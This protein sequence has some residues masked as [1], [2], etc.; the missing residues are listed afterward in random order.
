MIMNK[1]EPKTN[2]N[3]TE[4]GNVLHPQ[5]NTSTQ[6]GYNIPAGGIPGVPIVPTGNT[7]TYDNRYASPAY[8]QAPV[9]ARRRDDEP[10]GPNTGI[11]FLIMLIMFAA[12][13]ATD[14]AWQIFYEDQVGGV[15]VTDWAVVSPSHKAASTGAS[16]AA[17][18][19]GAKRD[20][21][22]QASL[23]GSA[24]DALKAWEQSLSSFVPVEMSSDER[25]LYER[26]WQA[27]AEG[28][29]LYPALFPC[30]SGGECEVGFQTQK[31]LAVATAWMMLNDAQAET[32]AELPGARLHERLQAV[33]G[34]ENVDLTAY[35]ELV[36]DAGTDTFLTLGPVQAALS[37]RNWGTSEMLES[38]DGGRRVWRRQATP[39]ADCM[40]ASSN[41]ACVNTREYLELIKSPRGSWQVVS[42]KVIIQ[43]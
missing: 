17:D 16:V 22:C 28:S 30:A 18:N 43:E 11:I 4:S 27:Q 40:A 32:W 26:L 20:E 9:I 8:P 14:R 37:A 19:D 15:N 34:L 23:A 41:C 35:E 33:F 6:P 38:S 21:N 2:S 10:K 12:G 5:S 7:N 3:V 25:L 31:D 36:Y 29:S 13:I 24:H 42:Q 39:G 1:P